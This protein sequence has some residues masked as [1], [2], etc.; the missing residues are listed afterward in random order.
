M[1]TPETLERQVH[2]IHE[3]LERSNDNVTWNDHIP[4]PD[5]ASQLRQI[6]VTIRRNGKLT[7]VEC[8]LSRS[9]QNVKWIEEMMVRNVVR[10]DCGCC[11]VNRVLEIIRF[12]EFL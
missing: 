2:R 10:D 8:R 11:F 9:R 5:N 7:L 12:N 1:E 3:L 6:D 4:D